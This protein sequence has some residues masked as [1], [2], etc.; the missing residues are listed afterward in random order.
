MTVSGS[1]ADTTTSDP[2][3]LP[4][5]T[6]SAV[7]RRHRPYPTGVLYFGDENR[8]GNGNPGGAYFKF[9]PNTLWAVGGPAITDLANSPLASGS[10]YGMRIGKRSGKRSGNTDF[11]QGNE[12]GPTCGCPHRYRTDQYPR[13]RHHREVHQLYRPKDLTIDQKALAAGNVRVCGNNT[14]EDT[15]GVDNHSGE[16]A[17]ITD[18]TLAQAADTLTL[19]TPKYQPLVVGNVD[20]AMRDNIAYQPN[21][22]NWLINE[23]GEGPVATPPRNNDLVLPGRWCRQGQPLR[24]ERE[25]DESQRSHRRIDRRRLRCDRQALFRQHSSTTSPATA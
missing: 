1:S 12:F 4:P 10:I 19:S 5:G 9:I 18:G 22:G 23:D 11:G 24:R 2:A 20:F 6:G 14:G 3:R 13:R 17:C 7:V 15:Q 16:T 25:G 21:S 8:P